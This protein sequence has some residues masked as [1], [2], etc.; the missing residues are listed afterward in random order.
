METGDV[1]FRRLKDRE[2]GVNSDQDFSHDGAGMEH[3]CEDRVAGTMAFPS[4]VVG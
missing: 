3:G 4:E 2:S 1:E